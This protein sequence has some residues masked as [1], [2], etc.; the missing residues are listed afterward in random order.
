MHHIKIFFHSE[1]FLL[2]VQAWKCKKKNVSIASS[3][4]HLLSNFVTYLLWHQNYFGMESLP[5][6][7]SIPTLCLTHPLILK[8]FQPPI[9]QC[10]EIFIPP[11]ICSLGVIYIY[12]IFILKKRKRTTYL[13]LCFNLNLYKPSILLIYSIYTF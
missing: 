2:K 3:G 10:F 1:L 6:F 4:I 7:R 9:I 5:I 8:F 11:P 13:K 12:K